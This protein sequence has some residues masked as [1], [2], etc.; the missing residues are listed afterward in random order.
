MY[1]IED[2]LEG[3]ILC[4]TCDG[5]GGWDVATDPEVYDHWENCPDCE[6]TGEEQHERE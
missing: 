4:A 3:P 2:L 6:G 5:A 1:V